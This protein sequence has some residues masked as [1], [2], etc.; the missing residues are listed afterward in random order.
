MFNRKKMT[1][2]IVKKINSLPMPEI[3][4]IPV[5]E[6]MIAPYQRKVEHSRVK[7]MTGNFLPKAVGVILVSYRDGKYWCVDGQHRLEAMKLKGYKEAYCTVLTDLD[8]LEECLYFT[9]LNT[10]SSKLLYNQVFHGLIEGKNAEALALTEMFKKYRFDYNKNSANK[11]D[12]TIGCVKKFVDM[13]NEYGMY[14]VEK[15]LRILRNAWYG[16]KDSLAA[17]IV[18]GLKT[19]LNETTAVDE[20]ILVKALEKHHPHTIKLEA[21]RYLQGSFVNSIRH[22]DKHCYHVAK[23]IENLYQDEFYKVNNPTKRGRPRKEAV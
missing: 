3:K 15:V 23:I 20:Q 6:I 8:Y 18:E 7:R 19:F 14:M 21:E 22:T 17:A 1:E 16:D 13:K 5:E 2:T 9:I 12:N 4:V 11:F 10:G